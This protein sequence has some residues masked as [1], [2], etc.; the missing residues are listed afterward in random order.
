[1][2][3]RGPA[4]RAARSNGRAHRSGDFLAGALRLRLTGLGEITCQISPHRPPTG[5]ERVGDATLKHCDSGDSKLTFGSNALPVGFGAGQRIDT[6][7]LRVAAVALHPM[8]VDP[9]RRAGVDQL[10]P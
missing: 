1:T 5:L 6:I 10:L 9:V 4:G 8:P 3:C 7:I 2:G